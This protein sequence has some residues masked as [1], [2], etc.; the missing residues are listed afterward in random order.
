MMVAWCGPK[1]SIKKELS[2]ALQFAKLDMDQ[3]AALQ[4]HEIPEK[5]EAL[6]ARL[7]KD[8]SE[9][10]LADLEYQFRVIYTLDNASKSQAVFQFIAPGTQV[11]GEDQKRS[12]KA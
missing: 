7:R 10:D 4:Q 9:A 8:L 12:G 2:F 1:L 5:V 11:G 3:I 6:D